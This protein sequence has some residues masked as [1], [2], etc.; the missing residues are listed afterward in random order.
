MKKFPRIQQLGIKDC[1][2]ACLKMIG[3]F[4]G[5]SFDLNYLRQKC[6]INKIGVSML[7]ISEAAEAIGFRTLGVKVTTDKLIK[8]MD[9]VVHY[10]RPEVNDKRP[11]ENGCAFVALIPRDENA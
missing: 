1:G 5:K 10:L 7:G 11:P 2:P 3:K 9:A 8:A 4:Y 6:S